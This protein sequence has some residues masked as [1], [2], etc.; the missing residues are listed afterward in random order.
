MGAHMV[1]A[2]D[3]F[4]RRRLLAV[5]EM[6]LNGLDGTRALEISSGRKPALIGKGDGGLSGGC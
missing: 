2:E 1:E 4:R 3:L 5:E 6:P